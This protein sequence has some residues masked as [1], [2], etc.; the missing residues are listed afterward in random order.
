MQNKFTLKHITCL[1]V[2]LS[3]IIISTNNKAYCITLSDIMNSLNH[4]TNTK[5][6]SSLPKYVDINNDGK[7]SLN[8]IIYLIRQL[9]GENNNSD[10]SALSGIYSIIGSDNIWGDYLGQCEIRKNSNDQFIIIHTQVWN[11]SEFEGYK[12]ALVWEGNI[13]SENE[14]YLL[15]TVL[16]N[17]GFIT[18]YKDE[19]RQPLQQ[20]SI[21]KGELVRLTQN[22]FSI[23]YL[24]N[25]NND[26]YESNEI[27]NYIKACDDDPI[28]QNQ[29]IIVPTHSLIDIDTKQSMFNVFSSFHMLPEVENYVQQ[30]QFQESVHY[31]AWDRTDLNYY[32]KNPD[33]IRVIQHFPDNI[34]FAEAK[35]RNLAYSKTLSEKAEYFDISMSSQYSS[36]FINQAGMIV[37]SSGGFD[38]DS[39]EW[40]G[41]YVASQAL[42]YMTTKETIALNNMIN[43]LNGIILCYDIAPKKGDFAR[44]IRMHQEP[45]DGNWIHGQGK[46]DIYDWLTPANNDMVKGFF[47]GFTFAYLALQEADGNFEQIDHIKRIIRELL[48]YNEEIMGELKRP[49]NTF[50]GT[51]MMLMMTKPKSIFDLST[52]VDKTKLCGEYELLYTTLKPVIVDLGNGSTYE[53][54]IS[55]WSGNQLNMETMLVLYTIADVLEQDPFVMDAHKNDF[56]EGMRKALDNFNDFNLGLF[57]LVYATLGG[58]SQPHHSLQKTVWF[59]ES[60]PC[61]KTFNYFDWRINPQFCMSPFPALP[62]KF[63]WQ[64]P[65]EDRTQS[66]IAYPLFEQNPSNYQWKYNPFTYKNSAPKI[67]HAA[68]F[69]IAYWF[70]RFHG[71]IE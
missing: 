41:V 59:L 53:F 27:W 54:G 64:N 22:S 71:I 61:P 38:I 33:T 7:V 63:D 40:T 16:D 35:L 3:G 1:I 36:S 70:G 48:D 30:P 9:A 69:L 68:D 11:S 4:L 39:L 28:W 43:S 65:L 18:T 24:A 32:R 21:L 29:R 31:Q 2:L 58:Y 13:I 17:V 44:T 6:L 8:E 37:H 51:A 26:T 50:V 60:F 52:I 42:R 5:D 45:V 55:D 49:I 23:K 56:Q 57:H 47:I 62:W 19:K 15:N 12:K 66:L 46:Y 25:N 10:D 67:N 20:P 34:S 14:T